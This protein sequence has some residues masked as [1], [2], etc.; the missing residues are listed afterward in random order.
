MRGTAT[1]KDPD[2]FGFVDYALLAC[3]IVIA[4]LCV[5]STIAIVMSWLFHSE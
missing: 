1:Q 3:F 2:D 4:I 5:I